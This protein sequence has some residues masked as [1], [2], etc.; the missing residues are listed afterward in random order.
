MASSQKQLISELVEMIQTSPLSDGDKNLWYNA[1]I[2][3]HPIA[4]DTML[5][6]LK[7]SP[8]TLE[9]ATQLFAKKAQAIKTRNQPLWD[10]ILKEEKEVL[11]AS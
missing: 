9:Q 6:A 5:F 1:I 10:E 8:V 2:R 3:T 4:W 11:S 7:D